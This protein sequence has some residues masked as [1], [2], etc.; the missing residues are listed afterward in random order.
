[1]W[2]CLPPHCRNRKR[3]ECEGKEKFWALN[4]TL[5]PASARK[6]VDDQLDLAGVEAWQ[7]CWDS[8]NVIND[9]LSD[10]VD[11]G[12][13]DDVVIDS[14]RGVSRRGFWGRQHSRAAMGQLV[15]LALLG[16]AEQS[17]GPLSWDSPEKRFWRLSCPGK[18]MDKLFFPGAGLRCDW[19]FLP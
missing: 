15:G 12:D 16:D 17:E 18:W 9:L 6:M 4:P 5:L 3:A 7:P 2:L 11:T 13:M 8:F 14:L 1:M 19:Q 10:A